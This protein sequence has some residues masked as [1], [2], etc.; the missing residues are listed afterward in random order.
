MGAT[1]MGIASVHQLVKSY[2][3]WIICW[4]SYTPKGLEG[5]RKGKT[6]NTRKEL[7]NS[8]GA[9]RLARGP[10]LANGSKTRKGPVNSQGTYLLD[11]NQIVPT[12]RQLA[13]Y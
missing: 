7:V 10:K 4:G 5:A 11:T 3:F 6:K 8:Q 2:F 13:P 12:L 1:G 9:R